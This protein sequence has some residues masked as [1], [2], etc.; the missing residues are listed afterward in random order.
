MP[1]QLSAY[2]TCILQYDV[3]QELTLASVDG[4]RSVLIYQLMRRLGPG[5]DGLLRRCMEL[6]AYAAKTNGA[7]LGLDPEG[8]W[9]VLA[10]RRALDALDAEQLSTWIADFMSTALS[11]LASLADGGL[12]AGAMHGDSLAFEGIRI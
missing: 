3:G 8:D 5:D 7:T 10:Q 9:I 12:P 6:N 2:G 4:D 1:K 11:V